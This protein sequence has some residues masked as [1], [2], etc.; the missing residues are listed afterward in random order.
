MAAA[1][2][3][4]TQHL[5]RAC[6]STC[7]VYNTYWRRCCVWGLLRLLLLVHGMQ[8]L[9]RGGGAAGAAAVSCGNQKLA[10]PIQSLSATSIASYC[11]H[12]S[13]AGNIMASLC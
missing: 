6:L 10:A 13:P 5:Q 4:M 11:R 9:L 7:N 3:M 2:R 1:T 12:T 8:Q